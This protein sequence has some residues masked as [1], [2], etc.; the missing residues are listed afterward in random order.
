VRRKLKCSEA[1]HKYPCGAIACIHVELELPWCT[2][3]K[4]NYVD[5][6]ENYKYVVQ[7]VVDVDMQLI[8]ILDKLELLGCWLSVDKQ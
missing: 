2:K 6:D 8:S 3:K 7:A 4:P 5:K 1:Y